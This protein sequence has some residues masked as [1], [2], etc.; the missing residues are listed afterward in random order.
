MIKNSSVKRLILIF[1]VLAI[2]VSS[3]PTAH[4]TALSYSTFSYTI[5]S[6]ANKTCKITG[7]TETNDVVIPSSINGYKVVTLGEGAFEDSD[8]DS[9]EIPST[10]KTIEKRCFG[11]TT[12]LKRVTIKSGLT[13]IG[14]YAFENSGITSIILPDTV[15]TIGDSAFSYCPD[16]KSV[17]LSKNISRLGKYIFDHCS[18]L[19]KLSF[20]S[21]KLTTLPERFAQYCEKLTSVNLGNSIKVIGESAFSE[22]TSLTKISLPENLT[23]INKFAFWQ[24]SSLVSIKL[25]SKLTTIGECAFWSCSSLKYVVLPSKLKTIGDS[26]FSNTAISGTLV[27]PGSVKSIGESAFSSCD[28]LKKVILKDGVESL[29]MN[30]FSFCDS[31]KLVSLPRTII[32]CAYAFD[33]CYELTI[34]GHKGSKADDEL[35]YSDDYV[36]HV[37][38][39]KVVKPTCAKGY[40]LYSCRCGYS[41]KGNYVKPITTKHKIVVI[42]PIRAT[43][44]RAGRTTGSYCSVCKSVF[45]Q[46][47]AI[48]KIGKVELSHEKLTY[49]GKIRKPTVSVY[50]TKGNRISS[51]F[52]TVIYSK[53]PKNIGIYSVYIKFKG[54]YSGAVKL[55]YEIVPKGTIISKI[56][57]IT[58]GVSINVKKQTS[59]T[60]GYQIQYALKKDFSDA[61][62]VNITKN[63]TLEKSIKGLK[64]AK[65]YY[66][67]VRTFK[68]VKI[69]KKNVAVGSV[70]SEPIKVRVCKS[71]GAFY[72]QTGKAPFL[73]GAAYNLSDISYSE[74]TCYYNENDVYFR[75]PNSC[76]G[77]YPDKVTIYRSTAKNGTYKKISVDCHSYFNEIFSFVDRNV[78]PNKAYYYKVKVLYIPNVYDMY[79]GNVDYSSLKPEEKIYDE[80]VVSEAFYTAPKPVKD[81]TG[82]GNTLS[83]NKVPGASGYFVEESVVEKLGYNIF[84]QPVFGV[85]DAEFICT[86]TS[87]KSRVKANQSWM[88]GGSINFDIYPYVVRNGYYYCAYKPVNKSIDV[89]SF[90]SYDKRV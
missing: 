6:K 75:L 72:N 90:I 80:T 44:N 2:M 5:I 79:Y 59:L 56:T 17:V 25:P 73:P 14:E 46:S 52:Y 62:H 31:L 34:H 26:A 38:T 24:C 42:K 16:L 70:W 65:Y 50:D 53:N 21:E 4:A 8:I 33:C 55:K 13:T 60:N 86:T 66:L 47:V 30:S 40:T 45:K 69:S 83:W 54:Y 74:Q 88:S 71:A 32:E 51:S 3:I 35:K 63:T 37:Y 41:Y 39:K 12:F 68:T 89:D 27:V 58:N 85:S 20:K 43:K 61:K 78:S 87:A 15:T 81:L 76:P 7:C 84:G 9:I 49:N 67:R 19:E 10:V 48:N 22:C 36:N 1:I 57:R 64:N 77:Y 23:S 82:Y 18:S 11:Y 29:G 28:N